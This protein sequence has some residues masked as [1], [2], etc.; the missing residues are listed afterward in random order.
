MSATDQNQKRHNQQYQNILSRFNKI[1]LVGLGQLGLPVIKYVKER[2]FDI[3]GYDSIANA[4]D[5]AEKIA[6]IKQ[7]VDFGS[8]HFDVFIISVSTHQPDDIFSPQIDRLLCIVDKISKEAKID[9]T[10][11]SLESTIQNGTSKK[12]FEML[13]LTIGQLR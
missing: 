6:E 1:L 4:I 11:L 3:Y 7:A 8:E 9:R 13:N 5:R 12:V 10:P 2:G